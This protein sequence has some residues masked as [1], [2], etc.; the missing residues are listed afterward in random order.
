MTP[1]LQ[2]PEQFDLGAA[3]RDTVDRG[4]TSV[5]GEVLSCR[6]LKGDFRSI[7][8]RDRSELVGELTPDEAARLVG[9][10]ATFWGVWKQH[11]RYGWQFAFD[12]VTIC[13]AQTPTATI[14]YLSR[15]GLGIN[16]SLAT[17]IFKEFGDQTMVVVRG[18]PARL[19]N[20]GLM[21]EEAANAAAVKLEAMARHERPRMELFA[22]FAG[23][24][25]S[26][27]TV[28][29]C[30]GE[31]GADAPSRVR[32]DPFSMLV[33]R[34]DGVGFKKA[35]ALYT[36]LGLPLHRVKRQLMAGWHALLNDGD[37]NTWEY[38][39]KVSKAIRA[40][41]GMIDFSDDPTGQAKMMR[42]LDRERAIALGLR[43]KWLRERD[44]HIAATERAQEEEMVALCVGRMLENA[45]TADGVKWPAVPQGDLSNHQFEKIQPLL[46]S[47]IGILAG[48]PGTG[49]TY[50]A[51]AIIREV[52]RVIPVEL[53]GVVA[54]T[55]KASVRITAAMNRYQLPLTATTIHRLLMG[56]PDGRF[57]FNASNKLPLK[58]VLVDETSMVDTSL[59]AALFA[60]LRR[61][62]LVL[63]VGDPYQLPPVGHGA[64][65]RDLIAA[66]VPCALLT[67]IQR[68]AGLIVRAC[69]AIKDGHPFADTAGRFTESPDEN[70]K[71]L[72]VDEANGPGGAVAQLLAVLEGCRARGIDPV[73]ETQVIVARNDDTPVSRK[74]LNGVLQNVLNPAQANLPAEKSNDKYRVGDKFICL[75]NQ[76]LSKTGPAR[77]GADAADVNSYPPPSAL[78]YVAN[79]DQGRVLA[80]S[81]GKIVVEF[82]SPDRLC[83]IDDKPAMNKDFDL[84]Y[85]ITC[86][87][88]QGSEYPFVI[89]MIDRNGWGVLS[90]EWI[91][92]AISRAAK[93]CLLIGDRAVAMRAILKVN[94]DKR[95][96]FLRELIRPEPAPTA[97]AAATVPA[98]AA[99]LSPTPAGAIVATSPAAA[100]DW[101]AFWNLAPTTTP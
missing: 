70:L 8:L 42:D 97:E 66:G 57:Q 36:A 37:G 67:E 46:R 5:T 41:V 79:G 87:K 25:L 1:T 80:V 56:G 54:P 84:A 40:A 13:P 27:K 65:L 53:C 35:D 94:L 99:V 76:Y 91:Y 2:K 26:K 48:T 101:I 22:L 39:G 38:R 20:A 77:A 73:W 7:T 14:N 29:A 18:A 34:L 86:H 32:R 60:A 28:E 85:A 64:P 61:D 12:G 96:T 55:G 90:R 23:H 44:D 89:V 51:A 6:A 58:V 72:H 82:S 9:L 30:L 63:L 75:R 78:S 83:V 47:Q 19:V 16:R 15:S 95:K 71:M 24:G 62:C 49:K 33:A 43:S 100:I 11:P 98:P 88:A 50:T 69:A 81:P 21:T 31:W 3:A 17:K 52:L 59:M 10:A 92:T 93:L 74:V 68:N 4:A 45:Q